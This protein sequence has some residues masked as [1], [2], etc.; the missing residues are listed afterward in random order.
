MVIWKYN[1]GI[2]GELE[3]PEGAKILTVQTQK[4]EP[5]IWALIDPKKPKKKR[6]FIALATGY[7][8]S[9]VVNKPYIGTYQIDDGDGVYHVFELS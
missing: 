7:N 3:I 2:D 1:L 5:Y 6:R 9:M 8:A 4:N